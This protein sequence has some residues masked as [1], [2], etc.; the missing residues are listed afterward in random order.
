MAKVKGFIS[1]ELLGIL[2]EKLLWFAGC[3]FL[4]EPK[5]KLTFIASM[6]VMAFS[7]PPGL[8]VHNDQFFHHEYISY[9]ISHKIKSI[10]PLRMQFFF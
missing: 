10:F 4:G 2:L 7:P 3:E 1:L 6:S 8:I 9:F 5:K